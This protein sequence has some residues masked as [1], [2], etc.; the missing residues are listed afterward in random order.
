MRIPSNSCAEYHR[1]DNRQGGDEDDPQLEN[2]ERRQRA[3]TSS[4]FV[5]RLTVS[6]TG[7][8]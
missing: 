8:N 2:P 6:Q 3:H 7:F 4:S 1:P 5:P